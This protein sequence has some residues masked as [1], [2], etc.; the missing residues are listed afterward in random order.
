VDAEQLK[1]RQAPLKQRC[2]DEPASAKWVL[3]AA[4]ELVALFAGAEEE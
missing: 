4:S 1:Q 2:R 3:K